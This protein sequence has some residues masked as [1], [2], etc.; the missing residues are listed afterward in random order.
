MIII[1]LRYPVN[2][3]SITNNYDKD[4]MAVDLGWNSNYGGSNQNIYSPHNGTII[5]VI[6]GKNN[7][8]LNKNDA[9]NIIRIKH[10]NEFTTRLIH[11]LKGSIKV[12]VGD[13][14]YEGDLLAQM[15]NSGYAIGNH[16]HYNVYLNNN[17]V[18]PL[19]YTY[20]YPDQIVSNKSKGKDQ[21]RY[22]NEIQLDDIYV[23]KK[24]DNLSEIGEL[25]NISHKKLAVYNNLKNPNLI[26]V[27]QKIK[28]PKYET[29]MLLKEGS[30]GKDVINIQKKLNQLGNN[31]VIDGIF[32]RK[33]KK[34]VEDFQKEHDLLV[35]G[36]VGQKISKALG[37]LYI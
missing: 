5:N 23:V 18:N 8:L 6:D 33:T 17:A 3:I 2:Y 32:G 25:Y 30:K 15:G 7:N 9:G 37:W 28:I 16:L 31:L 19:I 20:V 27:G 22:F 26:R 4:H 24:N 1:K 21:I 14:V 34:A 13:K 36:I 12:K 35:D 10:N 11:L 29:S